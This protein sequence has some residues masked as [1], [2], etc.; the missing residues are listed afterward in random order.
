MG[1]NIN[2]FHVERKDIFYTVKTDLVS[3]RII[4]LY[5]EGHH[6]VLKKGDLDSS[7]KT[8]T[9]NLAI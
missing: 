9:S 4:Y 1:N 5:K 8:K 7:I 3:I 2:V 6:T